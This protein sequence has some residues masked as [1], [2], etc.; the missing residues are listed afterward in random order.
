MFLESQVNLAIFS[1]YFKHFDSRKTDFLD[2][3][4]K[5]LKTAGDGL[6]FVDN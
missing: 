1:T 6:G 3:S 2:P 4:K 5:V